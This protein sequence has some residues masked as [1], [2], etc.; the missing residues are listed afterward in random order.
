MRIISVRLR[1]LRE[2]SGLSVKELAQK[3]G[4][5]AAVIKSIE[6]GS[7]DMSRLKLGI[8]AAIANALD[9]TLDDVFTCEVGEISEKTLFRIC[10][11]GFVRI[12]LAGKIIPEKGMTAEFE[13]DI[14]CADDKTY[15]SEKQAKAALSGVHSVILGPYT[16]RGKSRRV[17]EVKE[18]F[19]ETVTVDSFGRETIDGERIYAEYE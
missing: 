3:A 11:T 17:Y 1:E 9:M 2:S 16:V 14:L 15:D 12:P 4:C 19:I 5:S 13:S 18:Y 8:A 7:C 10:T 6:Y